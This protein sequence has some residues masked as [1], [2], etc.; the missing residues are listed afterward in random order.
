MNESNKSD[1]LSKGINVLSLFDGIS[2]GQVAFERAGIK[3]NNYYA[4]EIEPNAI[5]ITMKNYPNTIQCGDVF[6]TDFTEFI[7]K[8]IDIVI[9]GSPCT[10][11][12]KAK[13]HTAKQKRELDTDGIGWKLF[14]KYV[15]CINTVKPKYFLSL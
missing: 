7:E 14:M 5:Q 8:D 1:N 3:V 12:S 11:W 9:G 6:D 2:C 4:F 15:E 10:F 13:C